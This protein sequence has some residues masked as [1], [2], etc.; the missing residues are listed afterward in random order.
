[1][2]SWRPRRDRDPGI[3][4]IQHVVVIMQENRS[5]DS[6]FGTFPGS[7]GIPMEDGYPTVCMPRAHGPC[8]A[9]FHDPYDEN[10]GA[11]HRA[12]DAITDIDGGRMDGFLRV[13]GASV[14]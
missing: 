12:P 1:M 11:A 3:H 4:K 14:E 5:F 10:F 8:L 2:L 6:Y 13:A 9:P 7:D